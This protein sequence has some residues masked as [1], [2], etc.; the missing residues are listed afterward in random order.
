MRKLKLDLEAIA[1]ESFTTASN[2]Q[3]IGTVEGQATDFFNPCKKLFPFTTNPTDTYNGT[4]AINGCGV[5]GAGSCV[6]TCGCSQPAS[7]NCPS[8]ASD[9]YCPTWDNSPECIDF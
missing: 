7:C 5:S 8:Y 3:V 4:C 6:E 2:P 1:V 9:C